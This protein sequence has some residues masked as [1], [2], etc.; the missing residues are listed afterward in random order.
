MIFYCTNCWSM[1]LESAKMCPFCGDDIT[2]RQARADY[3]DKLIAA[4]R[5]PEVGTPVCAAW[6]LGERHER[7]AVEPLI[8]LVHESSDPFIVEAAIEALGKIGD[9]AAREI[10]TT[11]LTHPNL[12]VRR[13]AEAAMTLLR[14]ENFLAR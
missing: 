10:L 7:G 8:A 3:V 6:I 5:H 11:A 9:K 1:V 14:R 13:K 12:R 2:A 4:L